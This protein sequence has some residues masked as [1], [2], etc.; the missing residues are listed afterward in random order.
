MSKQLQSDET[1]PQHPPCHKKRGTYPFWL[2]KLK[3]IWQGYNSQQ[4]NELKETFRLTW[5]VMQYGMLVMSSGN[6]VMAKGFVTHYAPFPHS[7]PEGNAS[8]D[9]DPRHSLVD[10]RVAVKWLEREI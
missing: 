4:G 5:L 7:A 9:C 2:G 1:R 10:K 6:M 8:P 3:V